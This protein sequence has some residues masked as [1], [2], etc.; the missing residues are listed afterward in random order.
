M[1]GLPD[2]AIY[3]TYKRLARKK[4]R[5]HNA[6]FDDFDFYALGLAVRNFVLRFAKKGKN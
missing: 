4:R 1:R 5:K 2:S 3:G 6:G